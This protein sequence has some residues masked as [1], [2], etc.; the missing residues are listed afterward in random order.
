MAT[1]KSQSIFPAVKYQ[2]NHGFQ[3]YFNNHTLMVISLFVLKG[4]DT[5]IC[6]GA[7]LAGENITQDRIY[8]ILS[9]KLCMN[10]E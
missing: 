8:L 2:R 3:I 9:F 1:F 4:Y 5:Y 10:F 6:H 7:N